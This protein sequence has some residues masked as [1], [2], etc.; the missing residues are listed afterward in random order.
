MTMWQMYWL[1]KL[2]D[3]QHGCSTI[4]FSLLSI[5]VI[6]I[7]FAPLILLELEEH[8]KSLLL[9]HGKPVAKLCLGT[10]IICAAL[11]VFLPSTKQ[12]AAIIIVPQLS[13]AIAE[14]DKLQ[15]L[16]DKLITL[17]DDWITTL[18]PAVEKKDP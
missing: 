14:N 3:L 5:A 10:I 16:P 2:D 8:G 11:V 6:L 1:V 18:S 4:L 15:Q 13:S 12:M 7:M 17:A 9:L